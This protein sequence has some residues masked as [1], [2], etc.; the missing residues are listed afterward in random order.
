MNTPCKKAARPLLLA[1]ILWLTLGFMLGACG[2]FTA[3]PVP[4]TA[5]VPTSTPAPTSVANPAYVGTWQGKVVQP[6]F[7]SYEVLMVIT[8]LKYDSVVGGTE[9]PS[10]ECGFSLRLIDIKGGKY[11]LRE[12]IERVKPTGGCID[13]G[14]IHISLN[15]DGNLVWEWYFPDGKTGAYAVLTKQKSS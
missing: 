13:G 7:G 11:I 1:S 4:T 9:Y 6:N 3:T 15:S 12:K 2:D 5:A 8:E 10:L 14:A